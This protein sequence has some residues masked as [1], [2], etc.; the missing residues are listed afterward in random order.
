MTRAPCS[1]ANRRAVS[2]GNTHYLFAL[3]NQ[4]GNFEK[5]LDAYEKA[6]ATLRMAA[7]P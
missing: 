2:N 3:R 1:L 5:N 7:A 4:K 6:M